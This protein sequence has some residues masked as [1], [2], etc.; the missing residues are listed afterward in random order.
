[1]PLR[2]RNYVLF[3]VLLFFIIF[4][5][6]LLLIIISPHDKPSS[7]RSTSTN[8]T[9]SCQPG[10]TIILKNE[11]TNLFLANSPK[12]AGVCLLWRVTESGARVPV[13]RSYDNHDWE[14]YSGPYSS[15]S[16]T[17]NDSICQTSLPVTKNTQHYELIVYQR[18]RALRQDETAARF[19]EQTTFGPRLDEIR[20]FSNV[21]LPALAQWII[22]QVNLPVTS[23]RAEFRNHLNHRFPAQGITRVGRATRPCQAGTRYRRTA[24]SDKDL[25]A[26]VEIRTLSP[27]EKALLVGSNIRTVVNATHLYNKAEQRS[28]PLAD[29]K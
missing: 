23:H 11:T 25:G 18:R 19:L 10:E 17:C 6:F 13:A 1:M 14:A 2:R 20:A 9:L 8:A 12:S 27:T 4:V 7:V 24:F 29:G 5:L 22:D 15:L 28:E 3:S 26:Y 21:S 16:M